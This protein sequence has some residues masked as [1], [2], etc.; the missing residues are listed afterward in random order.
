V[1]VVGNSFAGLL[2]AQALADHADGVTIIDRDR[3]PDHPAHRAGV[4]QGRHIHVVLAGGQEA[5][6]S[7]LPGILNELARLGV[8]AVAHPRDLLQLNRSH[9]VPRWHESVPIL[10]GTRPL[11]E[12]AVRRRV[13]AHPGIGSRPSTEVVGLHGDRHRVRGVV[14]R[15]R[16]D[17]P[18]EPEVLEADLVV[19]ASGRSSRTPQ[20][21]AALGGTAP[22]EER[23]DTGLAYATRLYRANIEPAGGDY[24]GIYLV[25]HPAMPRAGVVLPIEEPGYYLVTLSGLGGDEPSTDPDQFEAYAQGLEHPII[26]EWLAQAQ[27]QAAPMGHRG[28]ANIR[29]RYDR[30]RGPDGLLVVGDAATAFN[31][32]YGQGITVA[33]VGAEAI[34]RAVAR[35]ERSVRRL[36]RVVRDA[37]EQAWSI[38]SSVDKGMP[39]A[40]GNAVHAS[41]TDRL[42][43][44]YLGRLQDFAPGYR[45]VTNAFRDVLHLLAPAGALFSWRVARSV[46]FGRRP[47][48]ITEP[49]LYA[50]PPTADR[51]VA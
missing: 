4:P 10:S 49:P 18:G 43:S 36:Q 31:P 42:G 13:L 39:G 35:G 23:I 14:V 6:E 37:G 15:A 19:D 33:A 50:D 8:P 27:A 40:T 48:P 16:A 26:A 7:M 22:A 47:R 5:L 2:T 30:L 3:I 46:L 34:G 25:P 44:W 45:H 21:L 29:R 38:C 17:P 24:R 41:P 1:V 20:W 12:H 9:W 28:T 11:V 51:T 32:I